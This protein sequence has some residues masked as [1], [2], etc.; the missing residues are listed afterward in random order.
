MTATKVMRSPEQ[1]WEI[2]QYAETH[3]LEETSKHYKVAQSSIHVWRNKFKN[4]ELKL[5]DQ[6]SLNLGSTLQE[7]TR[8][9]IIPPV[10]PPNKSLARVDDNLIKK[11]A[12]LEE[13]NAF[14]KKCVAYFSNE[15]KNR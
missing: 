9:Q 13:E 12:D 6:G 11:I 8:Q 15:G 10:V 7:A 14:L 1:K 5:A 2:V 4:G 3:T